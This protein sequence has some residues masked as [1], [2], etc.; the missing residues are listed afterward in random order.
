MGP[1]VIVTGVFV[2]L[3][4]LA[5]F[6]ACWPVMRDRQNS[7]GK[8]IVIAGCVALSIIVAGGGL[9][10]RLGSP[11]LA[12]RTVTGPGD[13]N[14]LVAALAFH[15]RQKNFDA[16]GWTLLGRGYL[17]LGDA[18]DAALAFRRAA[19]LSPPDRRPAMLS[20]YGEALT[21]SASGS[22]TSEAEQIFR[23]ALVGNP[24]DFGAR[25]YL[26]LAFA[27]RGKTQEAVAEWKSLLADT[28]PG[29]PWRTQLVDRL[30]ALEGVSDSA[31]DVSAMVMQLSNRLRTS[32]NDPEGWRRLVR[33]YAVLGKPDAAR[34]ALKQA[35]GA[36]RKNPAALA[37]LGEEAKSLGLR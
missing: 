15:A 30:A 24:R 8:R 26:G 13:I 16:M 36:L 22:V 32:P 12:L 9:Y 3:S 19:D 18:R 5:A 17:S 10:A 35:D 34:A 33:A 28:P 20:A 2:A 1:I 7:R 23:E 29:A 11:S 6:L 25:Y 21:M 14:S 27:E 31:P 4:L 37:L